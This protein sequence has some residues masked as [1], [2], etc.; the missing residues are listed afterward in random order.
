M[1]DTQKSHKKHIEGLAV[2]F[3]IGWAESL[4]NVCGPG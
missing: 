3:V 4:T 2:S 1:F